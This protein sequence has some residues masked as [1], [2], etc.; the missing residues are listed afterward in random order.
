[1]TNTQTNFERDLQTGF[2]GENILSN[3][4]IRKQ[5]ANSVKYVNNSDCDILIESGKYSGV[6][7]EVKYDQYPDTGNMIIEIFCLRRFKPT[8]LSVTKSKYFCYIF[9]HN[10][11]GY[12]IKVESLKEIIKNLNTKFVTNGG[13]NHNSVIIKLP[14]KQFINKFHKF[15]YE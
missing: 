1:M 11:I 3:Y 4:L 5:I 14:Y 13:D 10:K 2:I 6:M 15:K 12:I 8:G 9:K 7:F